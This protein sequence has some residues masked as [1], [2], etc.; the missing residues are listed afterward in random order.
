MKKH[1]VVYFVVCLFLI[2]QHAGASV[3]VRS[4]HMTSEFGVA[5]NSIRYIFQ[6]SKGFIWLGT[7]N[8]LN[9]YDG[10]SF[11][12]FRPEGEGKLSLP[13]HRIGSIAEDANGL[14]WVA[15]E[16]E[17][18]GCY[19][20]KQ[21]RFVD[22]TGCG[23]YLQHYN[24]RMVDSKGN[25]WLW[26]LGNG[27]RRIVYKDG[28]FT[29]FVFKSEQGNLPTNKVEYLYE[30]AQQR[31]WVGFSDGIGYIDG[32]KVEM[33]AASQA[34]F[35][36]LYH[37]GQV[38][39]LS[40][41][42]TV[43]TLSDGGRL[44]TLGQLDGRTTVYG[45]IHL[46]DTWFI[47]TQ[48]GGFEFDLKKHTFNRSNR[49]DVPRGVVGTDDKG[50]YWVSNHTGRL[51]YV[52]AENEQITSFQLI[53]ADKVN[54]ID[55][56]RFYTVL[57]SRGVLW[58]STYG[59]GLFAYN[60]ATGELQHF[61]SDTND[62]SDITTNFLQYIMEDRSGGLWISSEF[63]GLTHLTVVN[64]GAERILP[65]PNSLTDRANTVRMLQRMPDG[66][67][68]LGTRQGGTYAYDARL[69]HCLSEQQYPVNI[70]A[71][72][73]GPDGKK[74]LGS[75]GNGLG[76]D[77][78]WYVPTADPASL[79]SKQIFAIHRDSKDRMWIGTFG[80]GLNLAIKQGNDYVFRRFLD[81]A[82]SQRQIRCM[83]EDKNGW[84]WV[85]TS[86]GLY[87]F[88]PDELIK[89]PSQYI[90][91]DYVGGALQSDV[92]K[93]I[94]Q[95]SKGRIWL[96]TSG[97]GFSMCIPGTD[98]ESLQFKHYGVE[99]GL[100]NRMVQ[101][102]VEDRTGNLWISTEYG[103]SRFTPDSGSFEN[104]FFSTYALGNYYSDNSGCLSDDGKVLFGSGHGV[105]II[106]PQTASTDTSTPPVVSLTNLRVNGTLMHP[107]DT[108]SPLAHSLVYSDAIRLQHFQNSFTVD[109]STFDYEEP[110]VVKYTF[111]LDK[112]D[113]EWSVPSTLNFAT[114]KNLS[115]GVYTLRVKACSAS[116]V[117][118]Q[119][120]TV[121]KVTVLPPFWQ[122]GWAYF[123]YLLL[124]VVT[125]YVS[126]I[127]IRNF[128]ALRNRIEVERQLTEYKLVFFTNISHEFRTP[129]TLIQGA[130]EKIQRTGKVSRDI[131]S[132]LK[133]MEKSTQRMLRLINQLLEFRKMQN[134][135]LALSLEETDVIAF[136]YEIF[137]S[138]RDAAESKTMDFKFLPSVPQYKMFIDKENIDKVVYNLLSNAFKYTPCKGKVTLEVNVDEKAHQL[139]IRVTDTGVGIPKEKQGELFKRF[140]QSSFSGS[141]V[142]VGLHLTHELVNVHHGTI[143]FAENGG[144]GSVF[145]V[146]IPT[147]KSVYKEE[148]FLI[149]H[150][151]LLEEE[152]RHHEA[153]LA[154]ESARAEAEETT[155]EPPLAE[156][157]LNGR[158]ILV[159]EDD[160][161]VRD[162]LK[163]ELSHY[164]EV[165][166]AAE[167]TS[168]L[169]KAKNF[170]ADLI[171]CDVLMP[172]MN[173]FE[174]TRKLKTDFA[175]SHI[176]IILLT[177]M[178]TQESHLQG[179]ESGADAYITKPFSTKLLLTR[180]FKLIEQR[181]KLRE[182]FSNTP[183]IIVR[184]TICTSDKDKDFADRLQSILEQQLDNA[185]FSID[186]FATAMGLG[187]TVFYRKVRGVTG[188]SPNEYIRIVRMK[189][190]A[191]LLLEEKLT[192][193]EV[194]YRVGINDP[195]Y[196][197]KCFKQQFG[198][199][200]SAY[201]KLNG[202]IPNKQETEEKQ[203]NNE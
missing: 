190:A 202:I 201:I 12:T 126:W 163:E 39:F 5:N 161:D 127:L 139:L 96:G 193:S 135:K 87:V 164:F 6:D 105:V 180:V 70:Y 165:E 63:T 106:T 82:Y 123:V 134:N 50:H 128:S 47:F 103:V 35:S 11:I 33:V 29:S 122:T 191:S 8:G 84:M 144:G 143:A 10:N 25:I 177:A 7:I 21:D 178:S 183:G 94:L 118:S 166:V 38:F 55:E 40:K 187:R 111:R 14:L 54:F 153:M 92:V 1:F 196:F 125:L 75:R 58:M 51:W 197:S 145:T 64:Q 138:F 147:D 148:D 124:L 78:K 49:L 34:A 130:L 101:S 195:F 179:V 30:D 3:E 72:A 18:Y 9:R 185:Q 17:I 73:I 186:D 156:A 140:M 37:E 59:N 119:Q 76:I 188:Y 174:V 28:K 43:Y 117:W 158:K 200:P 2:C 56:E 19:D 171:I 154:E 20:L 132:S 149:P 65:E 107:G 115:P 80:A 176:P 155:V 116:G 27:I 83:L 85:G 184:P 57:D 113:K 133:I 81:D 151:V 26:H 172:G 89:N 44:R 168:G 121:L 77:G 129:L 152:A 23:E 162:F 86:A 69:S 198:V 181:E 150:N 62:T 157:P 32:D 112:Y 13:D 182:K 45:E 194:S 68:W 146:S 61:T 48:D 53:P 93:C 167:G 74:W 15:T 22:Y 173:G 88:R 98:Y 120:E 159:I 60:R 192:V 203:N 97:S 95:D 131:T 71:M 46:N 104:F 110:R 66:E 142:G 141:S 170:D 90:H 79:G 31:I 136:L 52:E 16:P 160:N 169:E 189:K 175:T 99:N 4:T 109:F 36:A 102:I 41:N 137:L 91:Y 100:V 67:I 24:H 108:D 199:S 114:Y 42:G